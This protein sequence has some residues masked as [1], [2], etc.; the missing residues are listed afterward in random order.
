MLWR[1]DSRLPQERVWF[2]EQLYPTTLA[3][4]FQATITFTGPL[5]A[6]VLE[7]SLSA[8]VRRHEIYRTT[9]RTIDGRPVQ[10]IHEAAPVKLPVVDLQTLPESEREATAQQFISEAI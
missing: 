10:V 3:Y 5:E 1:S 8:I 9:F 4:N 6:A 7:R 2:V